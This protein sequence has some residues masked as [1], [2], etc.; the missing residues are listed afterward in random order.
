[1][2][3]VFFLLT[4]VSLASGQPTVGL[5]SHTPKS[6]D[7][8]Y[9]LFPPPWH[10][11]YLIDKCGYVVHTWPS[12]YPPNASAYLMAD[13]SILRA[14]YADTLD[15]S[16]GG[17]VEHID[18]EGNLLW[19]YKIADN[20]H[21]QHH[22][23]RPL[24][25]GNILVLAWDAH[26]RDEAVA[27]GRDTATLG[28]EFWSEEILELAPVGSNGADIVWKW[29]LWD[30][31]I[32]HAD[33]AKANFGVVADHPELVNINFPA[34]NSSPDWLHA[35]SIAYNAGLDQI[36]IS[37]HHSSEMWIIDHGTSTAEAASHTG[38]RQG[39]GGDLLYR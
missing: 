28:A 32:Q 6:L 34:G 15:R 23:I 26:F 38:G 7:S 1:M 16:K 27:A 36:A 17:I 25:N 37:V 12:Q 9:V 33:A 10:E 31:L 13:G 18:W 5:I 11:T 20:I 2:R 21:R 22:D 19:S 35:N 8:G 14:A 39:R 3:A 29:R 30:H 24:P 4:A